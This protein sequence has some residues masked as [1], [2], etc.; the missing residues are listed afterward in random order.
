MKIATQ[1]IETIENNTSWK[2]KARIACQQGLLETLKTHPIG[3]FVVGAIES[4]N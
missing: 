3:A 4:W 1:T 2:Q